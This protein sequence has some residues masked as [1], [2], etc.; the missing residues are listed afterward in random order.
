MRRT[1]GVKVAGGAST[2]S[3][4]LREALDQKEEVKRVSRE[5]PRSEGN[6]REVKVGS[7]MAHTRLP[8][9]FEQLAQRLATRLQYAAFKVER[10]WVSLRNAV[11]AWK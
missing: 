3:T 10:G 9:L 4:A 11:S 6:G 8:N 5:R 1:S 2:S 7:L